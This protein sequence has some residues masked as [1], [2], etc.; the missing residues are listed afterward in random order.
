[1]QRAWYRD[2][3]LSLDEPETDLRTVAAHRQSV[4]ADRQ[5][6]DRPLCGR[7][8][9]GSAT[10]LETRTLPGALVSCPA[11]DA[12]ALRR[13]GQG[14]DATQGQ[15]R[16]W[17]ASSQPSPQDTH[18]GDSVTA[19]D[20]VAATVVTLSLV[21]AFGIICEMPGQLGC[22]LATRS[23]VLPLLGHSSSS[24]LDESSLDAHLLVAEACFRLCYTRQCS[25]RDALRRELW[26]IS[27]LAVPDH[28]QRG[29]VVTG[30]S[31]GTSNIR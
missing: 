31:A 28:S 19:S 23:N 17:R 13:Q 24:D 29:V 6:A 27:A 7:F 16:I 12:P 21:V 1:M 15:S 8:H 18:L 30:S 11:R 20:G 10:P 25:A 3:N 26:C 4:I 22:L 14:T 5:R 9:M 2:W